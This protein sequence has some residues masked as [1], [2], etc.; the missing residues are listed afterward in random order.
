M[1]AVILSRDTNS[2]TIIQ[3]LSLWGLYKAFNKWK[4]GTGNPLFR[5]FF[6]YS[7]KNYF[8]GTMDT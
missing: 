2:P 4:L 5:L 1:V 8:R 7:T 6:D 3:I